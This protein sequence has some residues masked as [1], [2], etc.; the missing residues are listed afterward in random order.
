M[1]ARLLRPARCQ[2]CGTITNRVITHGSI[3]V[4]EKEGCLN[5]AIREAGARMGVDPAEVEA[6]LPA[7]RANVRRAFDEV[8]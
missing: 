5:R 6:V 2:H 3:Y 8:D 7:T 1:G 4:C